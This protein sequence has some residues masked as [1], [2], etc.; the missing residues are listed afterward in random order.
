MAVRL[1]LQPPPSL[2]PSLSRGTS[3]R[4]EME[5]LLAPLLERLELQPRTTPAM[6]LLLVR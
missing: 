6:P 1:A 5:D 4:Q 3:L 2:P